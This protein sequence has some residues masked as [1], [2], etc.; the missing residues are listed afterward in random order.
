MQDAGDLQ[1]AGLGQAPAAGDVGGPV[2]QHVRAAPVQG[3]RS[4]Q[5]QRMAAGVDDALRINHHRTRAVDIACGQQR[6]VADLQQAGRVAQA[7]VGADLQGGVLDHQGPAGVGV[8]GGEVQDASAGGDQRARAADRTVQGQ[9]VQ[10]GVEAAGA[11]EL[12][13]AAER[14]VVQHHQLAVG[15][16]EGPAHIAQG[17]VGGQP[18]GGPASHHGPARIGVDRGEVQQAASLGDEGP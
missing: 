13:R 10:G 5:L 7:S 8:G 6:A 15:Q 14:D 18:Q 4:V 3:D 16:R 17:R 12:D 1:A 9:G 11:A 2:E